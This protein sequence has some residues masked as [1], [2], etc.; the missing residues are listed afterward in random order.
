MKII[1]YD[2]KINE[3]KMEDIVFHGI[4][5][6]SCLY[7][8]WGLLSGCNYR[9][10]YC[11]GQDSLNKKDFIPLYQ[12]K[13]AVDQIFKI[14]AEYYS[15]T[16]SGGEATYHPDALELIKYIYSFDKKISILL[17]TNGSK[18]IEYFEKIISAAKNNIFGCL[19]SIHLEYADINHI[20]DIIILFNKQKV[21]LN[22]ALMLHPELKE[23]TYSF[24]NEL[25]ELKK[26][27]HFHL[28]L[29]ELRTP[30]DFSNID[31]RY[32]KDFFDWID[33]ARQLLKSPELKTNINNNYNLPVE[34]FELANNNK[35][36][37]NHNL[38]LRN[39]LKN[40]GNFYCCGGI[41][42]ISI[43]PDGS[44]KGGVCTQFPIV[45]NIYTE[46]IDINYLSHFVVCHIPQCGCNA[47]DVIAKFRNFK[48]AKEY[49]S[50]Y[51]NKNMEAIMSYIP[52]SLIK[53]NKL[54]NNIDKKTNKIID[55]LAWFIP[56]R[57][58]RDNF[59]RK[60]KIKE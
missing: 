41:N 11:F 33:N 26:N 36:S 59:R 55:T 57:K 9:C 20:K 42:L 1:N 53:L 13:Y 30:P 4:K 43:S 17:I 3:I 27:Y 16:I 31:K 56:T 39:N 45:G 48:D 50:N 51:R 12:L 52:D 23:K 8:N 18:N 49:E 46:E 5:D 25:Y 6:S 32:D 35:I 19:I 60:F 2:D 28:Q 29:D 54:I 21:N 38:A 24:F 47:N 34:Y 37:I 7:I 22:F 40:F 14:N 44:Y 15:F 58:S 10:S